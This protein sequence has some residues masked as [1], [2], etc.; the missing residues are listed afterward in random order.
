MSQPPDSTVHIK[1]SEPPA[2]LFKITNPMI[3]FL[4][5]SPLHGLL[6]SQI[7]LLR[8]RGHKSGREYTTPVGYKQDGNTLTVFTFSG[9]K[10]NFR[11]P[12]P[13]EVKLRGEWH[14]GTGEIDDN[15]RHAAGFIKQSVEEGGQGEYR[16]FRMQV[17]G[18]REPTVDELIPEVQKRDMV[19]IRI[20]LED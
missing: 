10:A 4:L 7:M 17:E 11:Q 2:L 5:D 16:R 15:P 3:Q 9:W 20:Q 14:S 8:W 12:H 13:V 18:D 1:E 19:L 6:D